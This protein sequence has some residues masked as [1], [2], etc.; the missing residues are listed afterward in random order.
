MKIEIETDDIILKPITPVEIENESPLTPK[1]LAF[2][3]AYTQNE[4][5]YSNGTLSF[6]YAYGYNLEEADTTP[7]KDEQTGKE[8]P[9]SSDYDRMHNVCGV[10]ANRLLRNIKIQRE[11]TK[12]LNEALNEVNV[13]AQLSKVIQQDSRL[14]AK[15]QAI[16]EF[17]NL[18]GRI[19]KRADVTSGGERL[20]ILPAE[21]LAKHNLTKESATPLETLDN[22]G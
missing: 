9:K 17:N 8:I 1:Q 16:K 2:C 3:R 11:C 14:D 12:L 20:V 13:D 5:T 18:K 22:K 19:V 7:K 21:I 4:L 10:S 6:A 15:V